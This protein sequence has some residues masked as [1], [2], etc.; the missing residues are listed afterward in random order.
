MRHHTKSKGDIGVLKAQAARGG[1]V[2]VTHPDMRRY[3]MTIPEACQLVLQAAAMGRGGEIFILDMGEPVKIVD[4]ARGLLQQHE[5]MDRIAV[6]MMLRG[7]L[8]LAALSAGVLVTGSL[9]GGVLGLAAA[10]AVVLVVYDRGNAARFLSADEKWR[11][12]PRPHWRRAVLARVVWLALPLGVVAC[13]LSL[14]TNIPRYF[15]EHHLGLRAL[16]IFSALGYLMAAGNTVVGALGQSAW[17]RLAAHAAAGRL[18]DFAILLWKLTGL[19]VVLG[20]AGVLAALVRI[21]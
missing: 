15:V 18:T 21:V 14:I 13:L 2:T 12:V 1:P 5:R 8:S 3:F 7:V 9:L 17:P 6:S 16:G 11:G 10:W 19:G 4:L 20:I